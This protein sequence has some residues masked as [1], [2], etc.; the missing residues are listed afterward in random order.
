MKT[1]NLMP[2]VFLGHGSP[3]SAFE[4][5]SF[6]KSW[7]ELGNQIKRPSAIILLSAHWYTNDLRVTASKNLKTIYDFYGFPEYMYQY[8]YRGKS[9]EKLV[10]DVVKHTGALKD[11]E[12][13]LDHGAWCLLKHMYPKSDI[14][15]VQISISKNMNV[16]D[17]RELAK[18]LAQLRREGVLILGSGN[19]T[20]NLRNIDRSASG[21][22][23][24]W[25]VKYENKIRDIFN[26]GDDEALVQLLQSDETK[27]AH[28][29]IDH[30]I[31]AL[32]CSFFREEKEEIHYF[33]EEI[34]MGSLSMTS[35]VVK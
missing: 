35:F 34:V 6:T 27:I 3:L 18:D 11:Y 14:P 29:G 1:Q 10:E 21:V 8:D 23:F 28:S 12:W 19:I 5:N 30:L 25:A 4:E 24:D 31:P 33:N 32:I 15:V 20:H 9:N 17:Y 26:T 7:Q 2:V 22:V 13:G 16:S